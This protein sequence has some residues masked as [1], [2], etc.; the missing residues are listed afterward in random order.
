[1]NIKGRLDCISNTAWVT[2]DDSA[3]ATSYYV[4]ARAANGHNSSCTTTSSPCKV[5]DLNC[6]TLYNFT[7]KANNKLCSSTDNATFELET[8]I[9]QESL[10]SRCSL[11]V[12]TTFGAVRLKEIKG[13]Q[14]FF[15]NIISLV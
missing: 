14:L 1:M 15:F 6:G 9:Q 4:F 2:W 7:V 12:L 5:Q 13:K 8:G 11:C 10:P 3:G